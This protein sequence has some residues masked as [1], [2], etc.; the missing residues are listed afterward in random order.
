[1][2]CPEVFTSLCL[3][4]LLKLLVFELGEVARVFE[5]S[6]EAFL[7]ESILR[8][9]FDFTNGIDRCPKETFFIESVCVD[10][11]HLLFGISWLGNT[12]LDRCVLNRDSLA[13]FSLIDDNTLIG[14]IEVE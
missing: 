4:S 2:I 6:N 3:S 10:V 8:C 12:L 1:M 14:S 5:H 11:W 13:Q 7:V 9:L